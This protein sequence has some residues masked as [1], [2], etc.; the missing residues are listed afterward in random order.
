MRDLVAEQ[1]KYIIYGL[2]PERKGLGLKQGTEHRR[3][4]A[5]EESDA[6][7][8]L[9]TGVNSLQPV[10]HTQLRWGA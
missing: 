1:D 9:L 7:R 6:T 8:S 4:R 5:E 10:G 2:T 3:S